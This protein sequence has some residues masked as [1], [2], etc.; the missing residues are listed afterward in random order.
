MQV[1]FYPSTKRFFGNAGGEVTVYSRHVGRISFREELDG[2][3]GL[4]SALAA[5]SRRTEG[6]ILYSAD[7]DVYGT[8][9]RS[10]I[11]TDC[12]KLLGVSDATVVE[13]GAVFSAGSTVSLYDTSAGK[14]G[15]LVGEDL[16][17]YEPARSLSMAGSNLIVHIT[18][19]N[20]PE[21]VLCAEALAYFCGVPVLSACEGCALAADTEGKLLCAS[22]KDGT[23]VHIPAVAPRS[24]IKMRIRHGA[25]S[26]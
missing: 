23:A 21:S 6:V 7:T 24:Q 11:V 12:G 1:V 19:Q 18:R 13:D 22:P 10:V 4:L 25:G 20:R 26:K 14:I 3:T 9:H 8:L 5:E 16:Y 15:V 2:K 17:Y